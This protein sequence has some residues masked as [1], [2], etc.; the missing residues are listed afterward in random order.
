M[1][2]T[3]C[4]IY[5]KIILSDIY[6]Y[7]LTVDTNSERKRHM[8][9]EFKDYNIT[10]VNP[11]IGIGKCK[12][13]AIGFSKM[14]DLALRRQDRN[15]QFQPFIM[16]EDDCSKFREF[17]ECIEIPD[18][19]DFCYIGISE[20]SMKDSNSIQDAFYYKNV[21]SDVV[22]IYNMLAMHGI[23]V[24]SAAGALAIQKSILEC[25]FEDIAWDVC[26]A[27]IQYYYNVYA[28][29]IPLVYQDS[30]YGGQ[31]LKTK[32]TIPTTDENHELPLE[33]INTT[34]VS[35]ITC[36]NN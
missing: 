13:G 30:K 29:R 10:E 2:I 14:I 25:F 15:K 19:A 32:T 17:P 33:Y 21:N 18:N 27:Q 9:E 8:M 3:I 36:Q 12:S 7:F 26:V 11:I 31:E 1:S 34:N 4:N 5:M 6:H 35:V 24:C 23:M 28:L 22:R 20:C 16:Y